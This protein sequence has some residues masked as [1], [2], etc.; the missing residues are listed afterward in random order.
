[1]GSVV[2]LFLVFCVV[3]FVL[4]VFVLCLC[5]LRYLCPMSVY[6]TLPLSYVCV[7]YVTS[8]LCLC[9]IRY[10]CPMSV[11]PTLPLSYVCVPYVTSVLCLCTLRYLCPMSV[12]A[13]LP[14]S[15]NCP[16]LIAPPV[17]S[18]VYLYV[19]KNI[20]IFRL[21]LEFRNTKYSCT[22]VKIR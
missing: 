5:T 13:L 1:V 15:M 21:A 4:L 11:Y 18:N 12:Y 19:K 22:K 6:P 3:F 8:V 7:P 14:V 17:F 2:L 16:F 20:G 10:L 9:T